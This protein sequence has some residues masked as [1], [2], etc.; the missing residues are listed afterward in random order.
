M[1]NTA[2]LF[3]PLSEDNL[4]FSWGVQRSDFSPERQQM[5]L[6]KVSTITTILQSLNSFLPFRELAADFIQGSFSF[7]G[8]TALESICFLL[9]Y[10]GLSSRFLSFRGPI[11][12]CRVTSQPSHSGHSGHRPRAG[13]PFDRFSGLQWL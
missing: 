9:N 13:G 3:L 12:H 4:I 6:K 1:G 10:S 8:F 2:P 5:G 7:P 11:P